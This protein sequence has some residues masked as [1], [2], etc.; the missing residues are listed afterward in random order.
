MVKL[1]GPAPSS[2][3]KYLNQTQSHRKDWD[4]YTMHACFKQNYQ[5]VLI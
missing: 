3:L 2:T 5:K 1:K 4:H